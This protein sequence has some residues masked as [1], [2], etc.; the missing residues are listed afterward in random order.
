MC[1]KFTII[2]TRAEGRR[3]ITPCGCGYKEFN[4]SLQ[5]KS[6]WLLLIIKNL[7]NFLDNSSF[8]NCAQDSMCQFKE[9]FLHCH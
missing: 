7:F 8:K 1:T 3:E 9:S 6:L 5:L 2:I 4:E